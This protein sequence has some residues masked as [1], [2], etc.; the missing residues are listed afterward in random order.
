MKITI[1]SLGIIFQKKLNLM[2]YQK[3]RIKEVQDQLDERPRKVI[4]Y[5][6]PKDNRLVS[7]SLLT[8]K[9]ICN[10]FYNTF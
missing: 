4:D 10:F 2:K 1:A 8:I 6:I 9:F 3:K 5:S 7:A